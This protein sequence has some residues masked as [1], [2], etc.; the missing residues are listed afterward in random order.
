MKRTYKSRIYPTDKQKEKL[1]LCL[2]LCKDLYNA[3]L[4]E[5]IMVY[6]EKGA[7]VG[8]CDQAKWLHP[9]KEEMPEYNEVFSQVLQST[10]RRLDV[11]YKN[12]FGR[13]KKGKVGKKAGFPRFKSMGR[14]NSITYPQSGFEIKS[15]TKIHVSKIGFIRA[16]IHRPV[17]GTIKTMTLKKDNVGDWFVVFT[18]ERPDKEKTA[19]AEP[20]VEGIDVGIRKLA[21]VSNEEVVSAVKFYSLSQERLRF[22][23]QSL[24][25]KQKGS[26]NREKARLKLA[27]VHRK[28]ERQRDNYLHKASHRLAHMD[29]DVIVFEK[30]KIENMVKNHCLAKSILD[31]AW[32][33]LIEYT[34]YKAEDAGKVVTKV[35]PRYTSQICSKCGK[36]RNISLSERIYKC[37][38]GFVMD[39]DLN[40]SRNIKDKRNQDV[41]TDC[42]E[43]V[44]K[45]YRVLASTGS[46]S[47][48]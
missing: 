9:I 14:F 41:G 2:R 1:H 7:T 4:Q 28:I 5:R 39:R 3:G 35:D 16:F 21:T 38:C 48:S 22:A 32:G 13:V 45:A 11:A 17:Q 40:A 46:I 8:Y 24:S 43:L 12:F 10:L 42:A 25:R 19:V 47:A 37:E 36:K 33:K 30:L 27:K 26:K 18:A 15:N 23:Q 34:T 44:N 29:A 20:K 6:K 31:M